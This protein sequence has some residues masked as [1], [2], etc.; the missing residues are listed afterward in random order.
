MNYGNGN[1]NGHRW[2]TFRE[3]RQD[4]D[5]FQKIGPQ[6]PGAV[7]DMLMQDNA[8]Y[9][10]S[11]AIVL[12]EKQF[13]WLKKR[14][15]TPIRVYFTGLS[16]PELDVAV[17]FV[18]VEIAGINET[19]RGFVDILDYGAYSLLRALGSAAKRRQVDIEIFSPRGKR[20][21]LRGVMPIDDQ[22]QMEEVFLTAI[23]SFQ[24]KPWSESEFLQ[25]FSEITNAFKSLGIKSI[26]DFIAAERAALEADE[27]LEA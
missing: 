15:A 19:F 3:K 24:K 2:Q 11:L 23:D 7:I 4:D 18:L 1:G 16:H 26:D 12:S 6:E 5:L 20:M 25:T 9:V 27:E 8:G 14:P 21:S 13:K 10:F 17:V 22:E